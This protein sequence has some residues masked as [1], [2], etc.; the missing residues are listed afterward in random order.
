MGVKCFEV[1]VL[2]GN[3]YNTKGSAIKFNMLVLGGK[4]SFLNVKFVVNVSL[5]K[6]WKRNKKVWLGRRGYGDCF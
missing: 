2:F 4:N 3:F 1:F 6:F 5:L